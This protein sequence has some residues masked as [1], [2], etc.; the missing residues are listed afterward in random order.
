VKKTVV[1]NRSTIAKGIAVSIAALIGAS[2][3]IFAILRY[4]PFTPLAKI[5]NFQAINPNNPVVF[6]TSY[7]RSLAPIEE[8]QDSLMATPLAMFLA[9]L[10]LGIYARSARLVPFK[11]AI[12]GAWTGIATTVVIVAFPWFVMHMASKIA[13]GRPAQIVNFSLSLP[14]VSIALAELALSTV[15]YALGAWLI[16]R[17]RLADNAN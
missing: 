9:G 12:V 17:R 16:A 11:A 13:P 5:L 15:A 8:L 4:T 1:P 2:L 3:I 14:S 10:V 7:Y 6:I